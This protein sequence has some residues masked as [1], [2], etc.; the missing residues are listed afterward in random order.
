MEWILDIVDAAQFLRQEAGIKLRWP[1]L[2][3][4]IVPTK[5]DFA[6]KHFSSVVASQANVQLVEVAKE[7]KDTTLKAKELPFCTVYLDTTETPEIQAER[8]ARDLIR[9]I[10]STRKRHGL[11]VT[12]SITLYIATKSTKLSKL[13][14]N[15]KESIASKVGAISLKISKQLPETEG[16]RGKLKFGK[17]HIEFAFTATEK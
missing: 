5:E 11:H 1:C 13:I 2:R 16:A 6:L 3:L 15:A 4:I 10:Q 12:Q 17:H 8:V 14:R 9:R 7:V